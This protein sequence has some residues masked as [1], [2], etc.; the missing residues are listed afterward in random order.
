M[1]VLLFLVLQLVIAQTNRF[2][3]LGQKALAA[4]QAG[5]YQ[6]AVL[7]YQHMLRLDPANRDVR[8]DCALALNRLGRHRESLTTLGKPYDADSLALAG[9]NHRALG[10][11]PAAERDLRAAFKLSASPGIAADFGTLLLNQDKYKEAESVFG[12]C[13]QDSRCLAGI[14]LAAYAT[15]RNGDA[16][17]Q[18]AAAAALDPKDGDTRAALGDVFFATGRHDEAATAYEYAIRL[19]PLNPEYHVKAGRNLLRLDKEEP[20]RN[21]FA[22]ALQR[23]PLSAEA[24]LELGRMA[25]AVR[26]DTVARRHLE[27]SAAIDPGRETAHYQLGLLYR[28]LGDVTRAAASLRRL[29]QLKK[30]NLPYRVEM[31]QPVVVLESPPEERRWGRYQFPSLYRM[32]DGRLICFVHVEADSADSYGMP[33]RVFVSSDQGLSWRE[34][35]EAGNQAYGLRLGP[36][37]WLRIDTTSSL[38]VEGLS[39]PSVAGTL[40]SYKQPF[41]LYRWPEL[42]ADLRRIFFKR[43]VRGVWTDESAV[44]D[45]PEGMRY[46]VGGKFPRIWWGD[47]EAGTDGTLTAVTYPHISSKGPPFHFECASWRSVDRGRSWRLLSR[48]PYQPDSQKDPKAMDRDGFTEP[49]VARLRDGSLLAVLRTTDGNGV[50]PMYSARSVDGGRTWTKPVVIAENGVL[51]RLLRMGNGMLVLASGRSGVQLRFSKTGL[52]DDWSDPVDLLPPTSD[53]IDADSCGYT[54]LLPLDSDNF[55][56]VYSWFQKPDA[57]GN[58]RKAVLARRIR[59]TPQKPTAGRQPK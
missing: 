54:N 47:I 51:P 48:I 56:I 23:D 45:D 13:P 4:A 17:K 59:L 57:Q 41:F 10:N 39:L 25:S 36:S 27:A 53:K 2:E 26:D 21:H 52:G 28:R 29:E 14:G 5:R 16:E 44:V 58:P 55:V 3:E 20:A 19:D 32:A 12:R 9:I 40:T 35:R 18:L 34:D 49:A 31:A 24:H 8:Y 7:A 38:N 46:S 50:G 22:V 42:P 15:G 11:F 30:E 6:E 1:Y 37:E 33:Q 43:W